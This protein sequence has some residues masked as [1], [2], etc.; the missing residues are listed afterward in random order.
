MGPDSDTLTASSAFHGSAQCR[1]RARG[2]ATN[3]RS[4]AVR[5][6]AGTHTIQNSTSSI[7]VPGIPGTW[8]P[9]V[10]PG[11]N[12]W[13]MT[14]FARKPE[15]GQAVWAFQM[16]PHDQW[17]YD[18]VN[19]MILA[20]IKIDGQQVPALVHFDRN[21]FAFELNRETGKPVLIQKFDS[22]VNLG[23]RLRSRE[24]PPDRGSAIYYAPGTQHERHLSGVDRLEGSAA[25]I[26]RSADG[27]LHR[28]DQPLV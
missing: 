18:G 25:C 12:K 7:T 10:R 11:D 6:G 14:I 16:T 22:S 5:P 19:E 2:V 13:S 23:E 26:V 20:D 17:D 1:R 8:N 21:G 28:S 15:T 4:A 27:L 9:S 24:R 3:G